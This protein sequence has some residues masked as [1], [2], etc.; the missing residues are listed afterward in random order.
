MYG[1]DEKTCAKFNKD[2]V[3]FLTYNPDHM[4]NFLKNEGYSL[5]E[6]RKQIIKSFPK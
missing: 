6:Q 3:G 5:E 1:T 2:N 4:D